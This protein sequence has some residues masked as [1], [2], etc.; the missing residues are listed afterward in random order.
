MAE[1]IIMPKMGFNMDKGTLL[2]WLKKQGE[3]IAKGE[4]LFEIQTDKITMEIEASC[5]GT[6]LRLLAEA[7]QEIPVTVPIAVIGEPGEDIE[8]MLAETQKA[9]AAQV[10]EKASNTI[11]AKTKEVTSKI[12]IPVKAKDIKLSPR[13]RKYAQ[14]HQLDVVGLAIAGTGRDGIV[15]EADLVKYVNG[16]SQQPQDEG[17][18]LETEGVV[19]VDQLGRKIVRTVPYTGMRKIVGDRLSHSKF[20]APHLYFLRAVDMSEVIALHKQ[21]N[22][23][24]STPSS[25]NDYIVMAVAKALQSYP[26]LNASLSGSEIIQYQSV[27]IGIAVALDNG[28][29]VP[30]VKDIQ[31]QNLLE[32]SLASKEMIK[33]AREGK[34]M[35]E[36]YQSGT[37][38]ISNLG[39]FGIDSFTAII[40]PPETGILAV[41]SIVKKQVVV[42]EGD[43][44]AVAIR[45]IMNLT[46]TVDHRLIDGVT[47]V[48]FLNAVKNNLEKPINV[49]F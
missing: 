33:K 39:M 1:F 27:N 3:A 6:V 23:S 32:L 48:K 40:N 38:T 4:G 25:L 34:L 9:S 45:P 29:I 49:L 19:N 15:T 2:K 8:A 46:L 42:T 11:E 18:V 5:G 26:E 37:F 21:V 30:V 24:Q 44:D 47:A 16:N 41:S 13:A 36:E 28:L 35:P 31:S 7:G 14:A 43:Q 10:Q 22:A 17:P 20:T 12:S